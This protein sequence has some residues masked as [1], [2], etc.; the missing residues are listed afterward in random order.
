MFYMAYRLLGLGPTVTI[1]YWSEKIA[2]VMTFFFFKFGIP[3]SKG[4]FVWKNCESSCL[5]ES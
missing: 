4:L 2:T 3:F 1:K 5:R